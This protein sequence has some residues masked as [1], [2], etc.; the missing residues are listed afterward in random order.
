[1]TT[2]QQCS[3]IMRLLVFMALTFGFLGFLGSR[4][5]DVTASPALG[6]EVHVSLE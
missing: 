2:A 4:G 3:S 5:A 6:P 1:M